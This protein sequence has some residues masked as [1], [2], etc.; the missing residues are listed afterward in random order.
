MIF[1]QD[2]ESLQDTVQ[3]ELQQCAHGFDGAFFLRG[4]IQYVP[5][6]HGREGLLGSEQ[7]RF[8]NKFEL[9]RVTPEMTGMMG[10]DKP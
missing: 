1:L 8:Q 10:K 2:L 9:H 4:T 3:V 6:L 5:Y 7:Q